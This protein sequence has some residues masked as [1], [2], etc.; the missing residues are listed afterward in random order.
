[1]ETIEFS[2]VSLKI[3]KN[4]V[5]WIDDSNRAM[6]YWITPEMFFMYCNAVGSGLFPLKNSKA[7]I[8][9][10]LCAVHFNNEIV[11][12][13]LV[14]WALIPFRSEK[15]AASVIKALYPHVRK[16]TAIEQII[17]ANLDIC[18]EFDLEML[19]NE[20][21]RSLANTQLMSPLIGTFADISLVNEEELLVRVSVKRTCAAVCVAAPSEK[22]FILTEDTTIPVASQPIHVGENRL[23]SQMIERVIA[24]PEL[25]RT[26]PSTCSSDL[27]KTLLKLTGITR[28]EALK[29]IITWTLKNEVNEEL[30]SL[31]SFDD[32]L[33]DIGIRALGA[34]GDTRIAEYLKTKLTIYKKPLL[35]SL[36]RTRPRMSNINERAFSPL[37]RK[38][39][40]FDHSK[41]YSKKRNHQTVDL[42]KNL[43]TKLK[44]KPE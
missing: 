31:Y 36:T 34:Y 12:N 38:L 5:E 15:T 16:H 9:I 1:M 19:V 28:E 8:D 41:Y 44:A 10:L 22:L 18:S 26:L 35:T 29:I 7:Q 4:A 33:L 20:E 43:V 17:E 32:S 6:P 2:N 24:V 21:H 11:I 3:E 42:M 40:H 13:R 27:L 14:A 37:Y 23:L 30:F 39:M 25:L